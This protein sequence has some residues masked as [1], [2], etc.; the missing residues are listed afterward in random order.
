MDNGFY[1]NLTYKNIPSLAQDEELQNLVNMVW[2]Y[3]DNFL[4]EKD[5]C[6]I[7][8]DTSYEMFFDGDFV[9]NYFY[10]TKMRINFEF[11]DEMNDV[12]SQ[13]ITVNFEDGYVY[14]NDDDDGLIHKKY[15]EEFDIY[16]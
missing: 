11:L 15:I 1:E 9:D 5:G 14:I 13:L 6:G 3:Y 8:N 12:I 2:N 4:Y 7:D 10:C 16:K